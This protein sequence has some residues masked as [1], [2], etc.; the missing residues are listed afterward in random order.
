[1]TFLQ[2][3]SKSQEIHSWT[4]YIVTWLTWMHSVSLK[5]VH[6]LHLAGFQNS[7]QLCFVSEALHIWA[8]HYHHHYRG[9]YSFT[10][11]IAVHMT[12]NTI[13]IHIDASSVCCECIN[14]QSAILTFVCMFLHVFI[15]K[16][17]RLIIWAINNKLNCHDSKNGHIR[18]KT[19]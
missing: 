17:I 13:H 12:L 19:I 2:G 1:M 6:Q 9:F 3:L 4:L 16:K 11:Y 7:L 15:I 14:K 8:R 5:R 10:H 18:A